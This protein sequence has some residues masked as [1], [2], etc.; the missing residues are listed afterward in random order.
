V[1]YAGKGLKKIKITGATEAAAAVINTPEFLAS[2][3]LFI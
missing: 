2:A 1:I 3:L